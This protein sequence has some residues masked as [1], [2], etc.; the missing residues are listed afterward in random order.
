[1]DSP[2][3]AVFTENNKAAIPAVAGEAGERRGQAHRE[4]HTPRQL[5][6]NTNSKTSVGM[7]NSTPATLFQKTKEEPDAA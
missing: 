2:E 4:G 5:D 3:A 7:S 6:V 1:M